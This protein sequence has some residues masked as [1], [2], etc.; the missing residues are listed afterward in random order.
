MEEKAKKINNT[1]KKSNPR[2]NG[3]R[4]DDREALMQ[5]IDDYF[6]H[7]DAKGIP[8]TV[9][10]F[11]VYLDMS[12]ATYSKYLKNEEGKIPEEVSTKF[13]MARERIEAQYE[14][15]LIT[16]KNVVGIIFTLKCHFGWQDNAEYKTEIHNHNSFGNLTDEQ[17]K[18]AINRFKINQEGDK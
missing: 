17:L 4:H 18:K 16:G 10:E 3:H 15:L 1:T 7:C 9:G 8:Y 11:C 14:R 12:R 5:K 6:V 13:K 2:K